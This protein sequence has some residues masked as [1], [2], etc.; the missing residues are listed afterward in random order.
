MVLLYE[1]VDMSRGNER[2]GRMEE[3]QDKKENVPRRESHSRFHPSPSS[4][5]LLLTGGACDAV[6]GGSADG[7]AGDDRRTAQDR[8][9]P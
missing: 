5:H 1:V 7:G 3:S 9:Y 8:R 6:C 2:R 4:L